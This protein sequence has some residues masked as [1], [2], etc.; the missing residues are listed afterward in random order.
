RAAPMIDVHELASDVLAGRQLGEEEA[1]AVLETPESELLDLVQAAG[2][3]RR[4]RFGNR[5]KLNYLVNL[6]S[7][8]CQENCS[9]CSQALGATAGPSSR[10]APASTAAG[11]GCA[12]WPVVGDRWIGT[13]TAWRA[14]PAPSR[15]SI[16][17]SR[18]APAWAS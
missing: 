6:K 5:V 10:P 16:R 3:V 8:L 11:R 4:A 15:A 17:A 12:S 9:Y 13:S 1:L 7:G 2:R 14:S 18:S